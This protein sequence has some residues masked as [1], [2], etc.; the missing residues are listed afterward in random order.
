MYGLVSVPSLLFRHLEIFKH[1]GDGET[2][3]KFTPVLQCNCLCLAGTMHY[4]AKVDV[5]CRV[6]GVL[7]IETLCR[8]F[9]RNNLNGFF[10]F[11][12]IWLNDLKQQSHKVIFH[13]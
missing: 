11:F 3:I 2:D 6:D 8:H 5:I 12:D 7:G 1:A 10:I 13:M 9:N 4:R